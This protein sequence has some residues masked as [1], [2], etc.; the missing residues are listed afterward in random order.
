MVNGDEEAED[1]D[2][3]KGKEESNEKKVGLWFYY[4]LVDTVAHLKEKK[5]W[6]SIFSHPPDFPTTFTETKKKAFLPFLKTHLISM[7]IYGAK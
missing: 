7:E 6:Q 1:K 3:G 2:L 4:F 5:S